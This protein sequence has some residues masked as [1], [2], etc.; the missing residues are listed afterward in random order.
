M[1]FLKQLIEESKRSPVRDNKHA[2]MI[3]KGGSVMS[4]RY[5]G[6][7]HAEVSAIRGFLSARSVKCCEKRIL[8]Q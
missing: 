3:I 8:Q 2:C 1:K 4:M 5:N 7:N 6:T